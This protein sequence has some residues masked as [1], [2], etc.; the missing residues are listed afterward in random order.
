M[1]RRCEERIIVLPARNAASALK[2]AKA[3]GKREEFDGKA[4][5]GNPL[6]FE[7]VGVMDLLELGTETQAEEVW[8]DIVTRKQPSERRE[9]LIPEEGALNAIYWERQ[10]KKDKP[11]KSRLEQPATTPRVGD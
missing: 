2:K 4:E 7:F 11:N 5:A 9:K 6:Y 10:H 3:Y 1:M 8:Y